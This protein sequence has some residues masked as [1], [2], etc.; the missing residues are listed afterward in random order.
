M[1]SNANSQGN[2]AESYNSLKVLIE[3]EYNAAINIE[4]DHFNIHFAAASL[5]LSLSKFE[6]SNIDK[7]SLIIEEMERLS[8]EFCSNT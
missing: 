2:F 4:P 7:V 5:Y 3:Q 8:P 6:A 1:L